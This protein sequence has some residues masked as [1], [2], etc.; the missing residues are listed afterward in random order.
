MERR[1]RMN[2]SLLGRVFPPFF[3]LLR[4]KDVTQ[5]IVR[6]FIFSFFFLSIVTTINRMEHRIL[7]LSH[8]QT[9]RV[10][11]SR[12]A[13]APLGVLLKVDRVVPRLPKSFFSR[14][15]P[16]TSGSPSPIEQCCRLSSVL[17]TPCGGACGTSQWW[18]ILGCPCSD[19]PTA[20]HHNWSPSR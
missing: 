7:F 11:G 10:V 3:F 14:L 4:T 1:L 20:P 8:T 16:F 17:Q 18:D 12:D 13:S 6:S 9:D 15:S 5:I 19:R 2:S